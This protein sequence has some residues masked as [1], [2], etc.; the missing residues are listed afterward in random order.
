MVTASR[1]PAAS[2]AQ[3]PDPGHT[4][5]RSD[6]IEAI[7][8]LVAENRGAPAKTSDIA[9]RLGVSPPTV[10]EAVQK[11]AREG[12]VEYRPYR[13]VTFTDA[14]AHLAASV[15]RRCA[16]L[17]RFLA[18]KLGLKADDARAEARRMEHAVSEAVIGGLC[19]LLGHPATALDGG[20]IERGRCC[21]AR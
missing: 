13:G 5:P 16:L 19:G 17:E 8:S 15:R 9:A 6:Y 20:E 7:R 14:G 3:E 18:E 2:P 21:A 10:T 4:T 12:L 1:P 11:L